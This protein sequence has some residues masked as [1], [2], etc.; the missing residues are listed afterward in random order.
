MRELI[1]ERG[2]KL[3]LLLLLSVELERGII[4]L[5]GF[6]FFSLAP[7]MELQVNIYIY[8]YTING[9]NLIRFGIYIYIYL[10]L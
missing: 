2:R 10:Y 8:I 5:G 3:L 7:L 6:I 1:N 4:A 9:S